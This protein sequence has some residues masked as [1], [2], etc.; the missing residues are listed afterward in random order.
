MLLAEKPIERDGVAGKDTAPLGVAGAAGVLLGDA[1]GDGVGVP[2]CVPL[3]VGVGEDEPAAEALPLG[4]GNAVGVAAD[5]APPLPLV[6]GNVEDALGAAA[7]VPVIVGVPDGG[8]P[9]D[10]VRE[11][12]PLPLGVTEGEGVAAPAA[13]PAGVPAGVPVGVSLL[14]ALL[15]GETDPVLEADAP[16]VREGAG[17]GGV[18]AAVPVAVPL[19][20]PLGVRL[21]AALALTVEEG[22]GGGVPAADAAG[23][24][25]GEPEP[26][27]VALGEGVALPEGVGE[28]EAVPLP[29]RV[30]VSGGLHRGAAARS[31]LLPKSVISSPAPGA[32]A[33]SPL[34]FAEKEELVPLKSGEPPLPM[35]PLPRKVATA[36]PRATSTTRTRRL[37]WSATYARPHT[38]T[39]TALGAENAAALPAP[40][41]KPGAPPPATVVTAPVASATARSA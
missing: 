24:P 19:G 8:A 27:G 26:E 31:K 34:M 17:G 29:E 33:A 6:G 15:L 36:P 21:L 12:V 5:D 10:A 38:S 11:R 25:A 3:C 4:E 23:V 32:L 7:A 28:G 37:P 35:V 2:L 40:S 16:A 18:P 9:G 22:V 39:A 1:A 20:V 41:E 14:V 13:D 30:A